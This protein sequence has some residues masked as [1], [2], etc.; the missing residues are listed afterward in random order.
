MFVADYAVADQAG[1]VN[2]IGGGATGI[3]INPQTGLTVPFALFV[4][5]T[6]PP[7][8][9]NDECAVEISLE[10]SGGELLSLPGPAPGL[11]QQPVR[12]G[13]AV[14]FEE[15]RFP[16]PVNAPARYLHARAQWVLNFATGLPLPVS[17]GYAW[18]V[19]IDDES[20]YDWF[21][22]FVVLGPVAGPVIG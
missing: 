3:G 14:R 11:P 17:Q 8:F 1:K 15:P 10:D 9:S 5:V 19:R 7:Q 6:V 21:E 20:H 13:Q 16:Q 22:R 4:S 2:I 12:V 18:R